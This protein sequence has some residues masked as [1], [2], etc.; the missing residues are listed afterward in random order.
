VADNVLVY[1][2]LGG[3]ALGLIAT[4][5]SRLLQ[6]AFYALQDTKTPAKIAVVRV[7]VS[8]AV[9]VPLMFYLN[10]IGVGEVAAFGGVS[11]ELYFGAVGL[12]VG[13]S[14]GAW[15]ELWRLLMAL[16]RHLEAP[17]G[18]PWARIGQMTALALGATIPAGALW[19]ALPAWPVAAEATVVVGVYAAVYL[20]AAFA[21]G[22]DELDAWLGR[23]R[24]RA[25]GQ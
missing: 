15:V 16:R 25:G 3:Y 10:T 6:N 1:A 20:G 5:I 21:L 18:V 23:L 9:A 11:N 13:A 7:V 19:W 12:A 4:T 24:G 22:F 2:V 17:L 14:A 8:V